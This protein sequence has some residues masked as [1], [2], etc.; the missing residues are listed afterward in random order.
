MLFD[1]NNK[2]KHAQ[3]ID[4]HGFLLKHVTFILLR[5]KRGCF[6]PLKPAKSGLALRQA[7][8]TRK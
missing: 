5:I 8:K 4:F 3:G 1:L 7:K 6:L 2:K